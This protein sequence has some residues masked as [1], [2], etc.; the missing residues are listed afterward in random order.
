M[1]ALWADALLRS[2]LQGALAGLLVWGVVRLFPRIP[3]STQVWLWRIVAVKFVLGLILP[4]TIEKP[5]NFSNIKGDVGQLPSTILVL[6]VLGVLLALAATIYDAIT[7]R[8]LTKGALST[9][10]IE[11]RAIAREMGLRGKPRIMV[12][13]DLARPLLVG[14]ARPTILIPP[15][16]D[17]TDLRMVLA[18][19]MAHIRRRDLQYGWLVVILE[20]LFFFHPVTWILKRE[21]RMAQEIACD[22]LAMKTSQTSLGAYGRMLL[23]MTISGSR[24]ELAL[25]AQM[26]GTYSTLKQRIVRLQQ[27]ERRLKP[28]S[29]LAL[30]LLALALLPTWR[31]EAVSH[32]PKP[33]TPSRMPMASVAARIDPTSLGSRV[34]LKEA[35]PQ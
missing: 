35:T 27:S 31:A 22:A 6:S 10:P 16:L 15:D 23:T 7:A 26:A 29:V 2:S 13:H 32:T 8:K 17:A 12:K 9:E 30:G 19:E 33:S 34:M 14:V 20:A 28:Q 3:A 24:R 1:S 5:A 11:A 4:V 25:T 21:L 18:H